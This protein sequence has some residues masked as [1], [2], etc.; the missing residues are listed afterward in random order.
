[1]P[2]S[3]GMAL[4]RLQCLE[5]HKPDQIEVI[6]RTIHEYIKKGYARK[7]SDRD[8]QES[9]NAR[10]WYLPIFTVTHPKKP[11]KIRVVFDGAAKVNG[12]SLNSLLLKGPDQLSSLVDILRRF[13]EKCVA[14]AG[15][16]T[17]K[18]SR[19]NMCWT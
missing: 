17:E 14:A 3:Y 8:I 2:D 12:V 18:R 4:K 9:Q 5:R 7:L 11:E 10:V 19:I 15:D 16:I 1:M 13:R 6:D